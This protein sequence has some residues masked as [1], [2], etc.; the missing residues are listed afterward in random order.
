MKKEMNKMWHLCSNCIDAIKSRGEKVFVGDT[1]YQ[2]IEYDKE[3]GEWKQKYDPD[4][5][6]MKCEWCEEIDATLFECI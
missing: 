3:K 1:I 6:I 4:E 2:D 5:P